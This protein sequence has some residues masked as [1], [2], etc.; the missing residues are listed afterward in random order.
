MSRLTGL[1]LT[2]GYTAILINTVRLGDAY[3][4]VTSP[5]LRKEP[6]MGADHSKECPAVCRGPD[7]WTEEESWGTEKISRE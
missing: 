4:P 3:K 6:P 7:S 1:S 5:N 2:T